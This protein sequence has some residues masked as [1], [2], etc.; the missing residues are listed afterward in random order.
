GGWGVADWS[1]NDDKLL[2][3]EGISINESRIY[4][5]DVA[6][7]T[8]T[9][10]LPEKDERTSYSPICFS[11]DG[12][13]IYLTTTKEN[14]F[15]RLAYYDLASKKLSYL[16]SDIK[17]DIDNTEISK[18]GAQLAFAANENGTSKLYILSTAT[19]QYTAA[20]G[21]PVGVIGSMY[22]APDSKSLGV[23]VVTYNSV[24]DVYEYSTET[25]AI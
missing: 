5:V 1:P 2:V 17:W 19:N 16:T 25:K 8:K 9:R 21:L 22:W 13:G 4:L 23:S 6:S 11:K 3:Q 10:V 24:L 20:S 12:S 15:N 7:G 18:D 14:E